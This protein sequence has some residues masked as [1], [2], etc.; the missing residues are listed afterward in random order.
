ME[1]YISGFGGS[2]EGWRWVG[3][4]YVQG[5]PTFRETF[6]VPSRGVDGS[7]QFFSK[8]QMVDAVGKVVCCN[9]TVYIYIQVHLNKL[10]YRGKVHLFQ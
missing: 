3:E 8:R 10:E 1:K 4:T 2:R 9:G 5:R 7:M 6:S